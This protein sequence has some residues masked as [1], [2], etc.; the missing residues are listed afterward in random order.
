M[1]LHFSVDRRGVGSQVGVSPYFSNFWHTTTFINDERIM[2]KAVE[3]H[4]KAV[5]KIK[6]ASKTGYFSSL[7]LFQA[8]PSFYGR[9]AEERGGNVM[10]L[11]KAL[12]GRNAILVL[13]S[14][15]ISEDDIREL[16][17]QV[18]QDYLKE[19][20]DYAKSVDGYIDWTY[21][22][23]ADKTQSPLSTLSD[24]AAIN[25]TALKYDPEGVF[26]KRSPRGFKISDC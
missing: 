19:I 18:A 12:K 7:C 15:K 1:L 24:P 22:N 4:T 8:L 21:I 25:V 13:L 10:G 16:G 26:Q 11:D 3:A 23:Y 14:I 17:F 6:D 20:D 5:E 9:L 2:A